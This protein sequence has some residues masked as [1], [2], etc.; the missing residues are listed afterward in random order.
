VQPLLQVAVFDELVK[1]HPVKRKFTAL[2]VSINQTISKRLSVQW[3]T[4]IQVNSQVWV[5]TV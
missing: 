1:E 2:P 5:L 4:V 3:P